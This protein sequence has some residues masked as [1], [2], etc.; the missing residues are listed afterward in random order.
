[1]LYA[2]K[3]NTWTYLAMKKQ[4]AKI[5]CLEN[6]IWKLEEL[7]QRIV[8]IVLLEAIQLMKDYLV[9]TVALLAPVV[10]RQVPLEHHP[11]IRVKLAKL[12]SML[13]L[14]EPAAHCVLMES[15]QIN[16]EF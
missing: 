15:F 16:Q 10:K 13:P 1:M 4:L 2:R 7:E 11:L 9:I 8:K 3:G 5:V 6:I 14:L 12:G